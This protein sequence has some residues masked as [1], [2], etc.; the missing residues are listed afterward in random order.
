MSNTTTKIQELFSNKA[1]HTDLTVTQ[2]QRAL[3][4]PSIRKARAA[5]LTHSAYNEIIKENRDIEKCVYTLVDQGWLAITHSDSMS[6]NAVER[7]HVRT[8]DEKATDERRKA[9]EDL[10]VAIAKALGGGEKYTDDDAEKVTASG[11]S[12][13]FGSVTLTGPALHKLAE[14]LNL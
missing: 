3:G 2:I 14:L 6:N 8:D 9:R 4:A 1:P 5:Y 13:S 11:A 12:A 10:A 7:Y